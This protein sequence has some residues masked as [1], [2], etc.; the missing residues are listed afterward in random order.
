MEILHTPSQLTSPP[1]ASSYR[2]STAS[3]YLRRIS[4]TASPGPKGLLNAGLTSTSSLCTAG[5]HSASQQ[6][7]ASTGS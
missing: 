6:N 3:E 7:T 5:L 1:D 4:A 2:R